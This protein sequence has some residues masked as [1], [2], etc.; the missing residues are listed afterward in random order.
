M[1]LLAQWVNVYPIPTPSGPRGPLRDYHACRR[2]CRAKAGKVAVVYG[3]INR[4]IEELVRSCDPDVWEAV[5]TRARVDIDYFEGAAIY[6][7]HITHRL[8]A[9]AA[10]ELGVTE[11]ALLEQFGRYWIVYTSAE[12]WGPIL[13]GHGS[14]VAE[15]LRNLN[16]LHLRVRSTMPELRPPRFEVAEEQDGHIEVHYHSERDGLAAMVTGVLRGLA[17]R[18][19]EDWHV[20]HVGQLEAERCDV[21]VLTG[22][23]S[24][25][26]ASLASGQD[27]SV[28]PS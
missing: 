23:V 9:A 25:P 13:D 6:D 7:D 22:P 26:A 1:G 5:R 11:D 8:L 14:S 27:A 20:N 2:I 18:F 12:G 24:A 10:V 19:D 4:A 3:L 28:A 17:E 15:V 21:F 16:D